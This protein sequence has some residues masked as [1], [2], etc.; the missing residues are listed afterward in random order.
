MPTRPAVFGEEQSSVRDLC[1]FKA[2]DFSC[3]FF[4]FLVLLSILP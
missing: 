2:H 1:D 4:D 3:D